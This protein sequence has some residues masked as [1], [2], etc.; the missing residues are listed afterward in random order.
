MNMLLRHGSDEDGLWSV[1]RVPDEQFEDHRRLHRELKRL[2][3]EE[4]QHRN[5]ILG[6]LRLLGPF[7]VKVNKSLLARLV[8][9]S[10]SV[11]EMA[12]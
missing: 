8:H 9:S 6:L 4:T 3:N 7:F 12:A 5:R 10:T 1:L 2:K 11:G